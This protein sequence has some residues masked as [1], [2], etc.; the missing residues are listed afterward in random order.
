MK[1]RIQKQKIGA[2]AGR[3]YIERYSKYAG[4]WEPLSYSG[5]PYIKPQ[6]YDKLD[7]AKMSCEQWLIDGDHF[8][9]FK[10]N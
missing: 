2:N 4:G 9:E 1:Y 7:T 3:F 8:E 5:G 6:Y 10:D